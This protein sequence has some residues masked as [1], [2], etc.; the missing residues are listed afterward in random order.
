MTFSIPFN[1]PAFPFSFRIGLWPIGWY[2][3][4][5]EEPSRCV[6]R[7]CVGPHGADAQNRARWRHLV[8]SPP[9]T[10]AHQHISFEL[11]LSAFKGADAVPL[12]PTAGAAR[13]SGHGSRL[14][15]TRRPRHGR[16]AGSA[17][18]AADGAGQ[19]LQGT[20]NESDP[21]IQRADQPLIA[22]CRWS[23]NTIQPL[24]ISCTRRSLAVVFSPA[25]WLTGPE[26]FRPDDKDRF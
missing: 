26:R 19:T 15:A 12:L 20:R 4:L 3:L 2:R 8:S 21:L 10:C 11:N 5:W 1:P 22:F 9:L 25:L 14:R 23:C 17:S 18:S 24:S 16:T 7:R 13:L 6:G